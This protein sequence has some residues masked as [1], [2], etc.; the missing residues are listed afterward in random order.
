M[1]GAPIPSILLGAL[2]PTPQPSGM[3]AE[4][5]RPS[6]HGLLQPPAPS[7]PH[8]LQQLTPCPPPAARV[9]GL[10]H[11]GLEPCLHLGHSWQ[12]G[13]LLWGLPCGF[14]GVQAAPGLGLHSLLPSSLVCTS[15]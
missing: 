12:R 4:G 11:G 5:Q 1:T 10:R 15:E 7:S 2:F 3:A 9:V 6:D 13:D 14:E 8:G